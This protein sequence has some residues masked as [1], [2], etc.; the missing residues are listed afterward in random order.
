[1]GIYWNSVLV[2]HPKCLWTA[3]HA[4]NGL[5]PSCKGSLRQHLSA[6]LLQHYCIDLGQW[7]NTSELFQKVIRVKRFWAKR[8]SHGLRPR[9]EDSLS[10][11]L[12][13]GYSHDCHAMERNALKS[14]TFWHVPK[15]LSF[16]VFFTAT[17]SIFIISMMASSSYHTDS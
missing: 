4:F 13:S 14:K 7:R 10:L 8:G 17:L 5:F 11:W 2:K 6:T 3:F 15:L 1:M 16:F 12:A 9:Q